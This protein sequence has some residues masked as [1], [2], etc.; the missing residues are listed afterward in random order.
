MLLSKARLDL[1]VRLSCIGCVA[2][3]GLVGCA[4]T[5][6]IDV[7]GGWAGTMTWTSGPMTSLNSSFAL[8]LVADGG[9][10]TGAAQFSSGYMKTFEI[11][12]S[13]EVHA[14]TVVLEATGQNPFTSPATTV[15]FAFD[16][17]ATATTMSGVG[18]QLVGGASY[19]FTWTATLVAPPAAES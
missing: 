4:V 8:N 6:P 10:V 3:A 2:L 11:P 19:T 17:E 1:L 7:S 12:V 5:A 16:G 15:R 14:D 13:G 9:S 18:T